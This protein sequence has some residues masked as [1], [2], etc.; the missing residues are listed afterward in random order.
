MTEFLLINKDKDSVAV[1]KKRLEYFSKRLRDDLYLFPSLNAYE[2]IEAP[3]DA[4]IIF[5]MIINTL[6]TPLETLDLAPLRDKIRIHFYVLRL[7]N[8]LKMDDSFSSPLREKINLLL[9]TKEIKE[10][11]IS[12]FLQDN[13]LP[14]S[15]DEFDKY[16]QGIL[17]FDFFDMEHKIIIGEETSIPIEL[18]SK[19]G[20]AFVIDWKKLSKYSKVS[21]VRGPLKMGPLKVRDHTL[22]AF[23]KI[24]E[25]GALFFLEDDYI[26]ISE[27]EIEY[28]ILL[29]EIDTSIPPFPLEYPDINREDFYNIV[30]DYYILTDTHQYE[31]FSSLIK[32]IDREFYQH[33]MG[34]IENRHQK[35][36]PS[37]SPIIFLDRENNSHQIDPEIFHLSNSSPDL[38]YK[39]NLSTNDTKILIDILYRV[40]RGRAFYHMDDEPGIISLLSLWSKRN[41]VAREISIGNFDRK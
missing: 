9:E 39:I 29:L 34:L 6:K 36:D 40:Y 2:N 37:K 35:K 33:A 22:A 12:L 5:A 11:S 14:H 23:S 1:D 25:I 15:K 24:I 19:D 10:Y 28:L 17:D 30:A 31:E 27:F 13:S 38:E 3:S 8:D 41:Y 21:L 32:G 7:I 20:H 16:F 18:I 4:L 26:P